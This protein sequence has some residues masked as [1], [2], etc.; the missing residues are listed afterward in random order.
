MVVFILDF[1]E[2]FYIKYRKLL[3]FKKVNN[4]IIFFMK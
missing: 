3:M 1:I 2:E 4:M